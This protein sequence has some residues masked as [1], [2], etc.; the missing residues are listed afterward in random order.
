MIAKDHPA[1]TL[2]VCARWS[3]GAT[4]PRQAYRSTLR[5]LVKKGIP[6]P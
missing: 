5:T 2:D 4:A 1:V 6:R 3:E